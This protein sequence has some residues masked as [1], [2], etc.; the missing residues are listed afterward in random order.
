MKD[1][2][3]EMIYKDGMASHLICNHCKERV[4]R[5]ILNVSRHHMYCLERKEGLVIAKTPEQEKL[6]DNWSINV[7]EKSE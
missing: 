3:F 6:F 5:G 7:P 2:D 1:Q 4:E